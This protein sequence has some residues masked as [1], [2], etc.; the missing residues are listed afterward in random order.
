MAKGKGLVYRLTM[1]R[2]DRP[3]FDVSKL[4]NNR[5]QLFKDIFFTRLGALIKV[6]LLVLLFSLPAI[7]IVFIFTMLL[8]PAHISTLPFSG[9]LGI[10]YPQAEDLSATIGAITLLYNFAMY[11]LLIPAIVIA[12]IGLAGGFNVIK[13]LAWG[14]GISVFNHFFSGIKKHFKQFFLCGLVFA[15]LIAI[16][17]FNLQFFADMTENPLPFSFPLG[18]LRIFGIAFCLISIIILA[19]MILFVTT[20]AATYK[21]KL[22]GLFKNSFL[23]S[24]ALLP[25]NLLILAISAIPLIAMMIPFANMIAFMFFTM[26]GFSFIILLW[27][28]YAHHIFDKYINDKVEGAEKNKGLHIQTEEEKLA[29]EERRRKA[30]NIRFVNPK[31]KKPVTSVEEGSTFEPLPTTFNRADLHRLAEEKE[32]V[33]QEIDKEYEEVENEVNEE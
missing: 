25:K 2:D 17:A 26:V 4:P 33:K 10:G 1:G 3:D 32:H 31:K 24:I 14:E 7:A 20:Q 8:I 28:V 9:N 11:A 6:N 29:K 27:T 21:L 15:L 30:T 23:L 16:I 5:F 19:C 13:L 22:W 18:A 12:A